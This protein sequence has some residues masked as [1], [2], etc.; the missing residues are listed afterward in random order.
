[1][2]QQ[3]LNVLSFSNFLFSDMSKSLLLLVTEICLDLLNGNGLLMEL[4]LLK[5]IIHETWSFWSFLED[6]IC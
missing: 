5:R 3:L 4:G 2:A 6:M 1:M